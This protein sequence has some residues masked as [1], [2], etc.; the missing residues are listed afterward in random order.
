MKLLLT[1]AGITNQS[2]A[3]ALVELV[4]KPASEVKVGVV[5]TAE[6]VE[7][8]DKTLLLESITRLRSWGIGW[9]DVVDPSA[10]EV[11]WQDRLEQVDVVMVCGGN[12]FHL[13][14]QARKT[15][16]DSW[17]NDHL[18]SKVYVGISAGTI[19]ATPNI[20]VATIP[21]SD[22]NLPGLTDL[23]GM[24]WIDFEIEPHCDAKRFEVMK[25]YA[26]DKQRKV[27]AIDDQTAIKVV[28]KEIEVIS[29]GTWHLF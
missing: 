16:F 2:I 17:M 25:K 14:D 1:S 28:D 24:G 7:P 27:Y 11:Q 21:P 15:G 3:D 9:I 13:L 12:T 20:E 5:P 8:G 4:G 23:N 26:A 19:I 6:N 10:A 18:G 29:E 22:K